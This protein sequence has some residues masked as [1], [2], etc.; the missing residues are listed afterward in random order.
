MRKTSLFCLIGCLLFSC[1]KKEQADLIVHNAVVYTVDSS[2]TVAEAFAVKDGRFLAIGS[3]SEIL[4]SYRSTQILDAEGRPIYPGFIDAHCHFLRYGLGL[5]QADLTGTQSFAEAVERLSAHRRKYPVAEWIIGRGWDQNDW[6]VKQFPD[7]DT[8]DKLF[9]DTPVLL[10]RVD[11]HAALANGKALQL[12]GLT[13]KSK[14]SGGVVEVKN[15]RLTGI[16]VDNAIGL[17][18]RSVPAPSREET[19]AG[20][21]AAE[22]NCLAV[23][24]TTVDDA[25]LS[26]NEVAI[27]DSLYRA[28]QLFIRTYVMLNPSPE[29]REYYFQSGPY[30]TDQLNVRAFKVYADG[31]LGSR[32]AC[33]LNDYHDQSGKTGFLL[34]SPEALKELAAGIYQHGFQMNT[35]C[36]GDSANRLLLDYYGQLL[37]G[38]NDRR[39]RIEHAQVV[40]APDVAKFSRFSII[41]SVQPTHA[42]SD[43]Y[44]A[45]DRLGPE[46]VKTAY[47]Y[48]NLLRQNGMVALGSDFPVEDINPLYGFHSAVARQDEKG[49]PAGGFQPENALSREE[50]LR[51]MTIWAAWSNFEEQEKGSIGR[52]K[53][54]DFVMLDA[55]IM[56]AE[57]ARLRNVKVEKTYI[58][59]REMYNRAG[60]RVAGL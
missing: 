27:L 44:W 57:A 45:G 35:H 43:M 42:T 33:L 24:L 5:Q 9:P 50:A 48:K 18:R 31:A 12:A 6:P 53:F 51:G 34:S 55:D 60:D 14:V 26:R 11:G 56:K 21:K 15:G 37:K 2:F 3:S 30:K 36:I 7:R 49:Y 20:L 59:G 1:A 38:K 32:G 46:R 8:L 39:W 41:P 13:N 16:L 25:G 19:V 58:G 4:K 23:G 22:Q 47:A 29:T 54:A 10:T 28:S 17:V 40:S 52:G